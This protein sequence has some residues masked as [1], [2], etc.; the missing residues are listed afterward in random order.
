MEGKNAYASNLGVLEKVP[1]VGGSGINNNPEKNDQ[2][3]KVDKHNKGNKGDESHKPNKADKPKRGVTNKSRKG[4]KQDKGNESSD[5][6]DLDKSKMS[7]DADKQLDQC[8][9][10]GDDANSEPSDHDENC[11]TTRSVSPSGKSSYI[12]H[13]SYP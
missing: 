10:R 6:D 7:V 8:K 11:D 12:D 4:D 3:G 1:I 5:D 2:S 9:K 13:N